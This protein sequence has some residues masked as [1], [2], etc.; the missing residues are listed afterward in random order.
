MQNPVSVATLG[1]R[2]MLCALLQRVPR[3]DNPR[4]WAHHAVG[5]Q[6]RPNLIIMSSQLNR[7]SPYRSPSGAQKPFFA[8]SLFFA[9]RAGVVKPRQPLCDL[10][11]FDSIFLILRRVLPAPELFRPR[12][13]SS[14]RG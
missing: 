6:G 11:R 2:K 7:V 8:K 10:N 4:S 9:A 5:V 13:Q 12:F 3:L 14:L 1:E